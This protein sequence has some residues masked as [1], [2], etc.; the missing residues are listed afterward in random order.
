MVQR[1]QR[2]ARW[3]TARAMLAGVSLVLGIVWLALVVSGP[4]GRIAGDAAT[5]W[6]TVFVTSW[7]VA[8]LVVEAMAK[9]AGGREA[10]VPMP[11]NPG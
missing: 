11:R 5:F 7:V 4:F 6:L 1:L 9:R 3:R 8:D 2:L 10:T